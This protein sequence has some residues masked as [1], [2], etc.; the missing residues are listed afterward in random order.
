MCPWLGG[1]FAG[2]FPKVN[3][4]VL[5]KPIDLHQLRSCEFELL[6]RIERVVE[7]FHVA[8]A[9]GAELTLL[10]ST[11]HAIAICASDCPRRFAI[12]SSARTPLRLSPLKNTF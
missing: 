10:S 2:V 3:S 9:D 4:G 1:G 6:Q 12:S 11:T 8:S 5:G 7:L